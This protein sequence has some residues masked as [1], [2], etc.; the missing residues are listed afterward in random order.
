VHAGL[1][2][3]TTSPILGAFEDA[4][5]KDEEDVLGPG[6][7]LLLYTDGVIEARRGED[8]FG[9]KRLLALL[10]ELD[11]IAVPSIPGR[12]FASVLGYTSGRLSDDI[13]LVAVARTS[14]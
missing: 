1:L 6:D 10:S 5:F 9:E 13:A 3:Q 14:A 12:I 11:G 4:Q 8:L 7:V 2:L